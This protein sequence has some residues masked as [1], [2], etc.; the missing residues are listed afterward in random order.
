MTFDPCPFIPLAM[1]VRSTIS[2][3]A[4]FLT[5]MFMVL[6]DYLV[7]IPSPKLNVPDT[8]EVTHTRYLYI[9]PIPVS[10]WNEACKYEMFQHSLWRQE[11][12]LKKKQIF[13]VGHVYI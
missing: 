8:F 11:L 13:G 12:D 9:C 3:F 2:D 5:I 4:V 7:G 1:Q 6:L 10:V